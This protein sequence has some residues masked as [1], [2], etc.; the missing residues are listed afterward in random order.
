MGNLRNFIK[1]LGVIWLA[2]LACVMSVLFLMAVANGGQIL[3]VLT[4]F[5]EMWIEYIFLT[6]VV[7]P[8]C[9]VGLYY[10]VDDYDD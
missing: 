1:F 5:N 8:V 10:F 7:W 6:L 3:L 9:S 2:A 4:Y